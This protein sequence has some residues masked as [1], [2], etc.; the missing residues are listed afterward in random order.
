MNSLRRLAPDVF[1]EIT[2]AVKIIDFRNQLAHEYPNI[3]D[4]MVWAIVGRDV[5]VLGQES[6]E[7]LSRLGG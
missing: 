5:P 2:S 7:L 6:S 4:G 3:D 1:A